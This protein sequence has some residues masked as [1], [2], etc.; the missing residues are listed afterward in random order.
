MVYKQRKICYNTSTGA[1]SGILRTR[2]KATILAFSLP[3]EYLLQALFCFL[4]GDTGL[5]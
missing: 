1:D 4:L 2:K 5:Q 3:T